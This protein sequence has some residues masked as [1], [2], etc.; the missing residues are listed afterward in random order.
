MKKRGYLRI[1][2][3]ILGLVVAAGCSRT[4]LNPAKPNGKPKGTS[5]GAKRQQNAVKPQA[6]VAPET[7]PPGDIPDNQAFV[8]YKSPPGKFQIK[9]PEGWAQSTSSSGIAFSDK[10]NTVSV[11]WGQ[12]SAA[13]TV[14]RAKTVE[15]RELSRNEPAFQLVDVKQVA[16]PG[17]PAILINYRANSMPNQVTGKQYRLDVQRYEFFKGG[18]QANL[19]LSSPV[20]ADNVDPWKIVTESFTWL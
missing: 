2:I 9:V 11:K 17:G 12:A 16:L 6:P 20:G 10:L 7:N 19:I 13:P 5:G 1:V 14:E 15:A 8:V 4:A 3:V 18:N